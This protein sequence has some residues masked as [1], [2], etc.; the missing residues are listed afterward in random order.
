MRF[1]HTAD[2][3]VDSPLRGLGRFEGAPLD[4]LRGATR[5][6]LERLVDLAV[7]EKADF[8]LV[9]SDLYDRD[10]Q[11]FHT[12]LYVRELAAMAWIELVPASTCGDALIP[13]PGPA[14]PHPVAR[15][16]KVPGRASIHP[17]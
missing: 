11:D 6:A 16:A 9:A 5:R 10:W 17:S 15:R 8:V 13:R 7:E 4:R 3:H 12:D 14:A 2:L 1:I